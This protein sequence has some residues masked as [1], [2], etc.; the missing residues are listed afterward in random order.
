MSS[1]RTGRGMREGGEERPYTP[2]MTDVPIVEGF[3]ARSIQALPAQ[4]N[5][6][7][8]RDRSVR[9]LLYRNDMVY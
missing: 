3:F 4:E 8:S 5:S 9:R 2:C 6:S 7:L 1:R